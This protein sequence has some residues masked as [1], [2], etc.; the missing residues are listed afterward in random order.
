MHLL[1]DVIASSPSR[2]EEES[3]VSF[4]DEMVVLRGYRVEKEK[5]QMTSDDED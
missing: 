4:E 2:A 1:R 3:N 5:V